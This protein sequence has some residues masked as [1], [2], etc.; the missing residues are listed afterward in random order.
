MITAGAMRLPKAPDAPN[1]THFLTDYYA[2]DE[3][4]LKLVSF[5]HYNKNAWYKF[6]DREKIRISGRQLL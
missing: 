3:F 5:D 4:K 6:Y 1:K 2:A